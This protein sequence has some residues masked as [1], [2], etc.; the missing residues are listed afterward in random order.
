MPGFEKSKFAQNK[1]IKTT[2][3]ALQFVLGLSVIMMIYGL[4]SKDPLNP[5]NAINHDLIFNA[6]FLLG[7][8]IICI[9]LVIRFIPSRLLFDK[10]TDH[11]NFAERYR[12]QYEQKSEK[13]NEFLFLGIMVIIIAGILQIIVWLFTRPVLH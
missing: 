2:V 13:S 12:E 4:L 11:S 6:C 1:F 7:A 5:G 3:I 9:A 8:I 10:L